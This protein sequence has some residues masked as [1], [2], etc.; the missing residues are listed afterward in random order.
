MDFLEYTKELNEMVIG[1]Q[2]S[3]EVINEE[4]IIKAI[5]YINNMYI[6]NTG[7]CLIFLAALNLCNAYV[8]YDRNNI[9]YSF[10]KGIEYIIDVLNYRNINDIYINCVNNNGM[11]YLFQIGDIQFSFHD[12]KRVVIDNR[13]LKDL[14]W[15]GVRKQKCA[16]FIFESVIN[17]KLRVSNKTYRGKCLSNELDKLLDNYREK[18]IDIKDLMVF[19]I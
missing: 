19:K 9:G 13:Y 16:K 5:F 18:N 15:D 8:K 7:D 3:I 4:D 2:D 12:E 14:S 1:L 11:L 6:D 17:S 10:K